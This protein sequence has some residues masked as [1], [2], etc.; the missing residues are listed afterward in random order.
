M[1]AK[2]K[3]FLVAQEGPRR[4]KQNTKNTN[5]HLYSELWRCLPNLYRSQAPDQRMVMRLDLHLQLV[6]PVILVL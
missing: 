5:R 4:L 1:R 6:Y 2:Q 3:P